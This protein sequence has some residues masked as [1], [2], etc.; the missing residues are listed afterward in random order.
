MVYGLYDPLWHC[1]TALTAT[2]MAAVPV[3][4][5]W[6]VETN[7]IH[8]AAQAVLT[9]G[10]HELWVPKKVW[11]Q[12]PTSWWLPSNEP[13]EVYLKRPIDD[14]QKNQSASISDFPLLRLISGGKLYKNIHSTQNR[15]DLPIYRWFTY[16]IYPTYLVG[17]FNHLEKYESQWEGLSH[18][19][20]IKVMFETTNQ[21]WV[22]QPTSYG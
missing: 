6:R 5:S 2:E 4:E 21:L 20:K 17:G 8:Q 19:W 14:L 1:F 13:T 16:I 18:I 9:R 11:S 15:D 22:Y 7:S 3:I 12:D 10:C